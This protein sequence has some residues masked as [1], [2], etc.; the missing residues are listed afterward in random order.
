M[1]T[2]YQ[3]ELLKEQKEKLKAETWKIVAK[4]VEAIRTAANKP[5]GGGNEP[6]RFFITEKEIPGNWKYYPKDKNDFVVNSGGRQ[7]FSLVNPEFLK[8][9]AEKKYPGGVSSYT[10]P[11]GSTA[12][13]MPIGVATTISPKPTSYDKADAVKTMVKRGERSDFSAENITAGGCGATSVEGSFVCLFVKGKWVVE[14]NISGWPQKK[15]QEEQAKEQ[16]RHGGKPGNYVDQTA[17]TED[18]VR[19]LAKIVAVKIPTN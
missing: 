18:L 3:V 13:P 4:D 9:L 11:D 15:L 19:Q 5:R 12:Y 16:A 17:A 10:L 6:N 1:E 7:W 2:R 14:L 8:G